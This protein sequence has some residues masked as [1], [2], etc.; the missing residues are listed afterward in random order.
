MR[1]RDSWT[2]RL[3]DGGM[4]RN[5]RPVA[6][7][8]RRPVSLSLRLSVSLALFICLLAAPGRQAQQK[9]NAEQEVEAI[10]PPISSHVILIAIDGLR[11]DFVTGAE[12]QR[13]NIPTIQA[14]RSRGSYAV[15]IES[16]FPTQTIPAHASMITGSPPADHGVTS[17]FSFDQESGSQSSE[18]RKS[19]KEIKIETVFDLAR[20]ANMVTAAVGFPLTADAT[21]MFNQPDAAVDFVK[22]SAAAEIIEKHCPNLLLVNFTS[23]DETQRRYGLLSAESIKAMEAID[24]HIKKIIEATEKFRMIEDTTFIIVSDS[25]ASKV[26]KEYNPNVLL[27][28]KGWL[29]SDGRGQITSWRAVAQSFGGSAAVFVKDPKDEDFIHEVETFFAQQA[30]KPDSPIWRIITRIE[31]TKLGAD[32]RVALYIDAAPF[33]AITAKTTGSPI[34]NLTKGA[35]RTERGYAP[36]RMEM[37]ALF[38]IAGKGIISGK[39]TPY[40]RLIDIAPTVARLL[41]LEMK[42]ARGRVISEVIK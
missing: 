29:A 10:K 30:E 2:E 24:A 20:R 35:D 15:G 14:L 11:S 34:T 7:S 9:K 39:Q 37:R 19:A 22:A 1:Q 23:F 25:G 8:P 13:L 32:P 36:S 3:G 18:P 33:Y 38:V 27:A 12:S 28:K 40:A 42:T 31:A 17:D 26:E 6:Q 5:F 4:G 41:G 16:V 21:I